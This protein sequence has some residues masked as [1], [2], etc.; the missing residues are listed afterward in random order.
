MVELTVSRSAAV[1]TTDDVAVGTYVLDDPFKPY[2]HPLRTPAGHTVSL[3]MPHDH[4]HHKGLMYALATDDVNFWE[5]VGDDEHPRIGRQVQ[6][7]LDIAFTPAAPGITQRLSWV[8][9][10]GDEVFSEIRAVTCA[11]VADDTVRWT[12]DARLQ[13]S[14]DVALRM[15]PWAQPDSSGQL[16]NYHGL[17]LRFARSI[18]QHADHM[19]V[20]TDDGQASIAEVHGARVPRVGIAAA[21]DGFWVA[22]RVLV[23]IRQLDTNDGFFVL[24]HDFTTVSVG[25]SVLARPRLAQGEAIAARYEIEVADFGTVE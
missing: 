10:L 22:P 2:L 5:E 25:P 14:R 19:Q 23:S 24:S 7:D 3:A 20:V 12:W 11:R 16:V 18:G 6:T 21:I 8:D 1:F 15:S 4:R 13:A 17:G 9:D